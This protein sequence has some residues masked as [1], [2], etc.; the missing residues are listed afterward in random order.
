M[1]KQQSKSGGVTPKKR[2]RASY[3]LEPV[4]EAKLKEIATATHRSATQELRLLIDQRAVALGLE[5]VTPFARA[6][7]LDA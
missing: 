4:Y 2:N 1:V 5:P 7:G 6:T 3:S